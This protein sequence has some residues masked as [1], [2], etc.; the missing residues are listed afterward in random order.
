MSGP[1]PAD[2]PR[3]CLAVGDLGTKVDTL[4]EQVFR[5]ERLLDALTRGTSPD[6]QQA[7]PRPSTD[8]PA[9]EALWNQMDRIEALAS[10]IGSLCDR[11][12]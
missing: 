8:I 6:E 5:L 12:M 1:I 11:T 7:T 2:T 10:R 3:I 9:V 4:T